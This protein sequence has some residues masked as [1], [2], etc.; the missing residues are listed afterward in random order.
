[1]FPFI[2]RFPETARREMLILRILDEGL[3]LPPGQYTFYELYCT[4]DDCDCRRVMLQVLSPRLPGRVLATINYGW[5]SVAFYTRWMRGDAEAGSD[6]AGARL[7][8]LNPQSELADALL[9]G[10]QDFV[11]TR[12]EFIAQL[13]R[14]YELFKGPPPG[15]RSKRR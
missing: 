3:P 11:K 6:C 5:E 1:M 8:P 9:A 15:R 7:E 2:K 4:E 13:Q 10:F 12:P 14:H